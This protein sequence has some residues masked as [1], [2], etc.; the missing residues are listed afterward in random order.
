M[1]LNKIH[2]RWKDFKLNGWQ[3]DL[4]LIKPQTRSWLTSV[5]AAIAFFDSFNFP[6]C[7]R[8]SAFCPVHLLPR[9]NIHFSFL[10][11]ANNT[12]IG[13]LLIFVMSRF[14]LEIWYTI[15]RATNFLTLIYFLFHF[16]CLVVE[17]H[18]KQLWGEF[19]TSPTISNSYCRFPEP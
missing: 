8:I 5:A 17:A 15:S 18:Q 7:C 19:C 1:T 11:L 13:S 10:S 4:T 14:I 9:E 3:L 2:R 16:P 12:A 6:S